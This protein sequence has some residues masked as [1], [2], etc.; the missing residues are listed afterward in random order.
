M[1]DRPLSVYVCL[2][3]ILLNAL[4]WLAFGAITAVNALPSLPDQPL[5]KGVMAFLS[6]TITGLFLGAFIFLIKHNR[7]AYFIALGLLVATSLL[8]IFDQ[9]GLSDL[10]TLVIN[11]V[12]IVLLIKNR[13]W[14]LQGKSRLAG[15]N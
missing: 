4:V 1:T 7:I 12:P 9:F 14:Y 5:L 3:F 6:F 2:T 8:S 10:I 15:I 13:A 11:I